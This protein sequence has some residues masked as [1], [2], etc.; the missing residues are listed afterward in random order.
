MSATSGACVMMSSTRSRSRRA[1]TRMTSQEERA[2]CCKKRPTRTSHTPPT[3]SPVSTRSAPSAI[4]TSA[5]PVPQ[6][7]A[8]RVA[9]SRCPLHHQS[10]ARRMRPPSSGK[11]GTRLNTPTMRLM[12]TRYPATAWNAAEPSSRRSSARQSP[13]IA[14][15]VSGPTMAINISA[16]GVGGSASS[17]ETPPNT[18]NVMPPTGTSWS[19]A[20]RACESSC[21]KTDAKRSTAA[22]APCSQ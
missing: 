15:L 14:K 3:R 9:C 7:L 11:P 1:R 20:A 18:C 21:R 6:R 8:T 16:R 2:A 22:R 13:A 12:T 10:A 4:S 17:C 19:S 5:T